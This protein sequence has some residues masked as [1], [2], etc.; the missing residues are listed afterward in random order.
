MN[1]FTFPRA[2]DGRQCLAMV[3]FTQLGN[4]WEIDI[5]VIMSGIP[6]TIRIVLLPI[7]VTVIGLSNRLLYSGS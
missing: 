3:Q 2:F 7:E 4:Y 1:H 6:P 5:I